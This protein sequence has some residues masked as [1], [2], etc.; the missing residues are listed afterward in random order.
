MSGLFGL[1][2]SIANRMSFSIKLSAVVLIFLLPLCV[3]L[4]VVVSE[5]FKRIEQVEQ[6][7]Q[8]LELVV[9]FKALALSVAK[10]RGNMAQHLG[11]AQ[12]K[13]PVI[14]TIESSIAEQLETLLQWSKQKQYLLSGGS[15]DAGKM[16]KDHSALIELI[17]LAILTSAKDFDLNLQSDNNASLLSALLILHLPNLQEGLGVIRGKGAAALADQSLSV[18]ERVQLGSLLTSLRNMDAGVSNSLSL[19]ERNSEVSQS[20]G[21]SYEKF[22]NLK[23]QLF[24]VV[25]TK[26][27]NADAPAITNDEYFLL[28]TQVIEALTLFDADV[29]KS[30]LNHID[31]LREK[32]HLHFSLVIITALITIAIGL[33]FAIGISLSL[34]HS[35]ERLKV[36][37][38]NLQQGDF[39][40][41]IRVDSEDSLGEAAK[42]LTDMVQSVA[43]LLNHIQHSATDVND[44]A[45]QMQTVTD[46]SKKELD[47]QFLQTQQSASAAT[48]MAATVREV[49]RT[50]V[51]ASEA[52]EGARDSALEGRMKVSEAISKINTLSTNVEQAKDIVSNLQGD[53]TDISAVLEVIRSIA[54]QTNLLALNAAIEA[55]RAGEQ[56]RGFA[57]VADEVR[58]LAKRTQDSTAEIRTVI[59]KLQGRAATA[60]TIIHQSFNGANES[61]T[62][63]ASAGAALEKIVLGVEMM[64]DLNTQIA[65]AAEQQAAVAEQMSRNTQHLNDSADNILG[66]VEQTLGY[67]NKLRAE[68]VSLLENTMKF[69]T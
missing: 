49:A 17:H 35:S 55:A 50:C 13:E 68:A 63:T 62:S 64:R 3:V 27:L 56:G 52:T 23:Q 59:E 33:Y 19:L 12:N 10:H 60:V 39:S 41:T 40:Q 25:E 37:A 67:S 28:C 29:K 14:R 21:A 51:H 46:K 6:Q 7:H 53:V 9:Q 61:V 31:N 2:V 24:T 11:G 36:A 48:E 58:S 30:L 69:K 34:T 54:E 26:V 18:N 38:Y 32:T 1:A 8:G 42:N 5:D 45:V 44:L 4:G 16:F 15:A 57:V 66:Q 22:N 47:A 20:V 65:T 43:G